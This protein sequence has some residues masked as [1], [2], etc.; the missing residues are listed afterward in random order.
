MVT[1]TFSPFGARRAGHEAIAE[2]SEAR[3]AR[4]ACFSVCEVRKL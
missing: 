4:I 2:A 3:E 1:G